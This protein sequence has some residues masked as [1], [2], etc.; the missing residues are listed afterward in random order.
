MG[1]RSGPKGKF[2]RQ[3]GDPLA[4]EI[5][6]RERMNMKS[7]M[8]GA[9]ALLTLIGALFV[10]Q[11]AEQ[12]TP[13]ADAATGSIAALNVGTCLTTDDD[14]FK[15]DC[16]ALKKGGDGTGANGADIRTKNTEVSTLY[17]TYAHDPKTAGNEPRAILMDSDLLKISIADSDRDKRTGVLI[18][19]GPAA[20]NALFDTAPEI[21]ALGT[22]IDDDLGELD[23]PSDTNGIAYTHAEFNFITGNTDPVNAIETSGNHTLNFG[24]IA[25]PTVSPPFEPGDFDV[26]DGAEVR[27]Y[28]CLDTDVND[29]CTDATDEIVNLKDYIEVDEDASNGE[30]SGNTAPWLGVNA[31]VPTPGQL[32]ILAIYYQTSDRESLVGGEA[33]WTCGDDSAPTEERID[34]EDQWRCDYVDADDEGDPAGERK[35][36]TNVVYTSNERDR[37]TALEVM[38]SSDGDDRS[39]NLLLKETA[40]FSGRY[41]G[42]L[43]LTDANGDGRGNGS[44]TASKD[45]GLE[46]KDADGSAA[47]DDDENLTSASAAV[48]GVGSDPVTISYRDSDGKTQTLR[49]EID[50]QPPT[51]N[52]VAPVHKSSSGDQSPDFSGTIEDTDSGLVDKSF[53]LVVDNQIDGEGKNSDYVLSEGPVSA[54]NADG[55][56]GTGNDGMGIVTHGGE[57]S[58]YDPSAD[59]TVG[60]TMASDLYNLMDDS[61]S[62]QNLCHILAE[63]YDD[64]AN[65][66]EFDDSIRLDLKDGSEDAEIRDKEYEIDFQAFVMDMAGNIG[67]SDSDPANPR[68]INDLGT[69]ADDRKKPN[70]LGYYS[71]HIITLDEKDPEIMTDQTA[72]GFFG[73]NNNKNVRDRFGVMVVFDN[74]V[75]ASSVSTNTF[76][77][78]LDDE[79]MASVTEVDVDGKYVFLKLASELASDATP[80][81]D[82]ANGEKVED[83]AGNE[84]FGREVK[85]FEAKDGISPKLTVSLSGGSGS[86]TGNEGPEKLTKD[87]ITIQVS[88]DEPL[89]SSP[90]IA[91][92]CSDISWKTGGTASSTG[93]VAENADGV[94][95]HD[96]DDFVEAHHGSFS[97]KPEIMP[98]MTTPRSGTAPAYQFTCGYDADDDDFEDNF[99]WTDVPSLSRPGENW[100][101][102]WQNQPGEQ[103]MLRDGKVTAVAFARDRSSYSS[104]NWGSTS[105][106]F[107]FDNEA[108]ETAELQPADEGTSK[109]ARPFVLIRFDDSHSVT[110]NS[111]ELDDV[112]IASE[113]TQPEPNQFVY[114][115]LSLMRG[116]HEVAVEAS[117]AAG[118]ESTFE[119]SFTVEERGDFLLNLLAGWNAVSVPADPVDTAIG[120]VFTNPAID[121]VIGWDPDGWRI[122]SRRDGVW[123]SN[124]QYGTLNEIRSRYG[125]WVKSNNFV[126]QPIALTANDRGVGGPR[127]PVAIPTEPGWNFVGVID[128]DGDQTEGDS[129]LSLKAG[130]QPVMASEYLGSTFVRAYTWDA[131]FNRFEV[132]SKDDPMTI[133]DGVWVY[134]Q[135]GIAP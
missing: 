118:N 133:G 123:E 37:N 55:V 27:F 20:D 30:A 2:Y 32:L 130:N 81:L 79:S 58:G 85:E 69:K 29:N 99:Q 33:Y 11:S 121:T 112:E 91:V 98:N 93:A 83:M 88:S 84:T 12:H 50:T 122:A 124:Q 68:F 34:T 116:E 101:Y 70:V 89:Q 6:M 134:Y 78:E 67:F 49:V 8:L 90:R 94:M 60:V 132:L 22:A 59:D 3:Y 108:P 10:M 111:V 28:G 95:N 31:S 92:V 38:A 48:L 127:T 16:N 52:V 47:E 82:I 64:G 61:C 87:K 14:V 100:D 5:R 43:R 39:A 23:H 72:T 117:D 125:Y 21:T 63:A 9:L 119:Y 53:R 36:T 109:E 74:T 62:D 113:F 135:G 46:T 107:A 19:G 114:W 4:S 115:P 51:I 26:D 97:G 103:Q 56:M 45:W 41:E 128:Q 66:G 96:V 102:V 131:T 77:V 80:M 76:T 1:A 126:R 57:Y 44:G 54:P 110:L 86:G 71:A 73:R 17:A 15:G 25:S 13:T 65:R 35:E 105:A 7:K 129:G 106:E 120:A 40:R 24:Y 104:Q 18:G 75:E 42:F